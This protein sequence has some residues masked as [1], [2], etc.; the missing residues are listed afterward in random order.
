MN[1][2]PGFQLVTDCKLSS[3]SG[4]I[5]PGVPFSPLGNPPICGESLMIEST[6][7]LKQDW[8]AVVILV[9]WFQPQGSFDFAAY[10]A[11]YNAEVGQRVFADEAFRVQA[12]MQT[13]SGWVA[14]QMSDS[15]LFQPEADQADWVS[16]FVL[17]RAQASG[18]H[19]A[20]PPAERKELDAGCIR[21]QLSGPAQAFGHALYAQVL[22]SVMA[23]NVNSEPP[24]SLKLPNPPFVPM[25]RRVR[26]GI[27]STDLQNNASQIAS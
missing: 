23:A 6:G 27:K 17:Q 22:Q 15:R 11:A 24:A 12:S 10:Y 26:V 14:M 20:S 13:P 18:L 1:M 9:D 5:A 8:D 2:P 7:L 4:P 25:A 19:N 16:C 3:P 21:L